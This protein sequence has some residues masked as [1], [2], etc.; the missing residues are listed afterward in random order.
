MELELAYTRCRNSLVWAIEQ[1]QG[2]GELTQLEHIA[3][4]ITQAMTG[5]WR[6]FHTTEHIFEVGGSVDA[7][8]VLSALFHDLVYVQVDHG[9]SINISSYITPFVKEVKGQIV[10][11]PADELPSSRM[12][13]IVGTVFG[14]APGVILSPMSGQNEFLSALI[15]ALSLSPFLSE[16][17]IAEIAACI[18]ATIP[19][20]SVSSSGLTPSELL[21][22]RL[23]TANDQFNFG[24]SDVQTIEVVKR[25]VRIVNRDVENFAYA[26]SAD[27]LDN[28]WNLLPETNHELI[29][30]TNS[31]T[32]V[33]YRLSLQKMEGFM[34][35]LS[36]ERVFQQ[37]RGE[38]DDSTYLKLLKRTKK[39]LEVAKLY[40]GTKLV[41]IALIEALSASLGRD[42]PVSTMMGELPIPGIKTPALVDFLPDIQN[43]RKPSSELEI[44]VLGLLSQG[45]N[46]ESPYDLK[47]SPIATF[48]VK[49]IGFDQMA[50]LIK[51]SKEFFAGKISASEFLDK[52]DADVV[53]TIAVG[54]R[55]LFE[56]RAD[57]FMWIEAK[58][59]NHSCVLPNS[60]YCQEP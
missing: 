3:E 59:N 16:S 41:S 44:E 31:Y 48:I 14:Q 30:Y 15:A 47:N 25:A 18:E 51:F 33:G 37:F 13:D 9:V 42:I 56:S 19:F 45:R 53:R 4:L 2:K 6:Y 40:L 60:D 24:W 36:P 38:P 52:C 34:H 58:R 49:S 5:P 17:Q 8:E 35:F 22:Q 57:C 50:H 7:I 39:N 10:I 12:F 54:V 55:Q 28:T 1:L 27:F 23:V 29:N 46:Q 32:V 21:Y 26:N 11:R 20:R 43:P